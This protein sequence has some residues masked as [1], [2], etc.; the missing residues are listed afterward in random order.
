MSCGLMFPSGGNVRADLSI[1]RASHSNINMRV[2]KKPVK[3]LLES[4]SFVTRSSN[5][6]G[7]KAR[8]CQ[9]GSARVTNKSERV[10]AVALALVLL[11]FTRV[12][13][14]KIRKKGKPGREKCQS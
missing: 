7:R 11:P 2:A 8:P 14:V 12:T 6:S 4:Y 1:I 9:L 10:A 3:I 5:S 13:R